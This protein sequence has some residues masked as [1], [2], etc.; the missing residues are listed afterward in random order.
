M[1][2]RMIGAVLITGFLIC[3]CSTWNNTL[4]YVGLRDS[5][6]AA[7]PAEALP[8]TQTAPMPT[9]PDQAST[10]DDLCR[11]IGKAAGE[12]AAGEGFDAATQQR[13]TETAY[14]QCVAPAGS[15]SH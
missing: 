10:P 5:K 13:K 4:S 2:I 7:P 6:E 11:R 14:Q 9:L 12:E 1:N 15:S 8:T 3:G